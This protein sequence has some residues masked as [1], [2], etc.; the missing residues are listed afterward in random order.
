MH[1]NALTPSLIQEIV[2][3][4]RTRLSFADMATTAVIVLFV[5]G[6]APRAMAIQPSQFTFVH[7]PAE[8]PE[9]Q[10]TPAAAGSLPFPEWAEQLFETFTQTFSGPLQFYV[11]AIV[12]TDSYGY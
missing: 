5:I 3:E 10:S 8:G 6:S 7:P 1:I 2:M 12:W 4:V 9:P 11:G